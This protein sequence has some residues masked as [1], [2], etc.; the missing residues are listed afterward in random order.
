[1]FHTTHV[2]MNHRVLLP[3]LLQVH[4]LQS[5]EQLALTA[6][7]GVQRGGE[8]RLAE[9]ARAAQENV[10]GIVGQL[11]YQVGLVNIDIALLDN[12]LECLYPYR[13]FTSCSHHY[14]CRFSTLRA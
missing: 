12:S 8:Q 9:A 10:G 2:Q 3:L 11:P 13:V 7:I 5:L 6:E 1:M 4:D 14:L